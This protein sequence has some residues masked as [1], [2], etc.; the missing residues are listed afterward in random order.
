MADFLL[1]RGCRHCRPAPLSPSAV[2]VPRGAAV[3]SGQSAAAQA[4]HGAR[5]NAPGS[6][7]APR[8]PAPPS[9]SP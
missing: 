8:S 1:P 5:P 6:R 7:R 4:C 9:G 3:P 2:V